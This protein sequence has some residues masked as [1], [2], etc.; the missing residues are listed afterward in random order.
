MRDCLHN[1]VVLSRREFRIETSISSIVINPVGW[2]FLII[3][4]DDY[5]VSDIL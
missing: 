3:K 2:E 4:W 1:E 5:N